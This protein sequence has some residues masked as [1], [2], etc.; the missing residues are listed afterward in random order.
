MAT[1]ELCMSDV[2]HRLSSVC[3]PGARDGWQSG[4]YFIDASAKVVVLMMND[5][6]IGVVALY[7]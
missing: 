2:I 6:V 7:C 1:Q 4:L 3:Q 5:Y